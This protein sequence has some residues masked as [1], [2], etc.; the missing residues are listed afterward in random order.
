MINSWETENEGEE[1]SEM[2]VPG[3]KQTDIRG[4]NG[5]EITA[6][7]SSRVRWR[8]PETVHPPPHPPRT[9]SLIR[10]YNTERGLNRIKGRK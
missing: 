1:E 2:N 4:E 3:L 10:K 5:G 8:A 6:E 9:P 7:A